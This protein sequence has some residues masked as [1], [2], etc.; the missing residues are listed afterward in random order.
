MSEEKPVRYDKNGGYKIF[1]CAVRRISGVQRLGG[2]GTVG[3]GPRASQTWGAFRR[4]TQMTFPQ[5]PQ[6]QLSDLAWKHH[7]PGKRKHAH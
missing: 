3:R 5:D 6:G 1:V 4:P 7:M 2:A